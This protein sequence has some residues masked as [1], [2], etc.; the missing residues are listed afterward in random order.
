MPVWHSLYGEVVFKQ[1]KSYIKVRT[2]MIK[3]K[4]AYCLATLGVSIGII[5]AATTNS[6]AASSAIPD[7][8]EWQGKMTSLQAQN[9]KSQVSFVINRRQYGSSYV[10]KYATNNTAL[11]VKYGIPFGEYDYAMFTSPASAKTEAKNFYNRSNKSAKFYVLDYE[12]NNVTSGSSKAAVLAW[13]NEMRS[14]TNKKLV[15]YSYQSFATQYAG[16]ARNNFDAQWIANY[17]AKPTITT[18]LWQYTNKYYL[19]ALGK[20]VDNS[21]VVTHPASWWTGNSIASTA[22]ADTSVVTTPKYYHALNAAKQVT[23]NKKIYLYDSRTFSK[24]N[25][26]KTLSAGDSV[27]I[28][29]VTKRSTG[30]YYFTTTTGQ[31]ITA[32]RS[33]VNE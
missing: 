24:A 27:S 10:D 21:K 9:L 23:V 13:Y 30:S 28:Q 32:N 29:S 6:K 16:S 2:H 20:Y 25:R 18:D 4:I 8:S 17:S 14:L 7:V 19:A 5:G 15:F 3:R 11:Y 12:Q 33:Y 22:L 26:V 31:Y 1:I